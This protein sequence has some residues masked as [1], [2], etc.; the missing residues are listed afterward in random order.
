MAPSLSP[1]ARVAAV[2]VEYNSGEALSS[3]LRSLRKNRL[4]EIIVVDNSAQDTVL[5]P[6]VSRLPGVTV[7]VSDQNL[8]FG[9]GVNLGAASTDAELLLL[10]NPDV[11]LEV[12]AVAAMR[13]KLAASAR[14]GV[15]GPALIDGSN[16]VVQSARSFPMIRGSWKQAF[17]GLLH[18]SGRRSGEYR[19]RNWSR[20][21]GGKVD[22]VTGACL[23]VRAD[24]FREIGGF[25]NR[26]FLYVEEVDFCW[27]LRAAGW[28]TLYE[29]RARVKHTGGVS[30]SAHPYRAIAA[31]HRSLWVFIRRTTSGTYRGALPFV[32]IGL[33][34]RCG[35]ECALWATRVRNSGARG[36]PRG[37]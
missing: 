21:D 37:E 17:L 35:L 13:S 18:P 33:L 32:A 1:D 29:P 20:A 30:T 14:A 2:V 36:R 27:R 15:V 19:A 5:A 8:G 12:G 11:E 4:E 7:H 24:A 9:G 34:V 6:S 22:W 26:Y 23:L 16:R 3:C 31:H 25:D 10:C 28:E